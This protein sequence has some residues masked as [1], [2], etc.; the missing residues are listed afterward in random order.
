M[1]GIGM[2]ICNLQAYYVS[3]KGKCGLNEQSSPNDIVL[4]FTVL[5]SYYLDK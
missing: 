2:L 5:Q 4:L 1:Q 3:T